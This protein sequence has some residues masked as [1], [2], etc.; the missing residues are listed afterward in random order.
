ME[1]VMLRSDV[2]RGTPTWWRPKAASSGA[3]A[4]MAGLEANLGI[5]ENQAAVWSGFAEV[6]RS[7]RRRMQTVF[8]DD[9]P[10][11]VEHDRRAALEAM[12]RATRALFASLSASQQESARELLPLCCQ[13]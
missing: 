5:T 8:A 13:P 2:A 3:D 4:Y 10:F 1:V 9:H 11:G 12:R 7:N 6:L